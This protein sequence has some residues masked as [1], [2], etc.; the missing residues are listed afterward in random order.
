MQELRRN[1]HG[2]PE[3]RETGRWVKYEES[4][5]WGGDKWSKPHVASLS[6]HSL[7]ELRSVLL[8]SAVA[9]DIEAETIDDVAG[10]NNRRTRKLHRSICSMS[11]VA[12]SLKLLPCH[13]LR[14]IWFVHDMAYT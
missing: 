7:F 3:W 5:E 13:F 8:S 11:W 9:L 12:G 4:I 10:K 1:A 6:L 14:L 2:L